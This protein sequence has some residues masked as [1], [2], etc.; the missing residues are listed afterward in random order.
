VY[1]VSAIPNSQDE[2]LQT[3]EGYGTDELTSREHMLAQSTSSSVTELTRDGHLGDFIGKEAAHQSQVN[4]SNGHTSMQ[5]ESY[6]S[7]GLTSREHTPAQSNSSP[8]TE[9]TRDGLL[10]ENGDFSSSS[11]QMGNNQIALEHTHC[12]NIETPPNQE[13]DSNDNWDLSSIMS[14][15]SST[16]GAELMISQPTNML[17]LGSQDDDSV[18]SGLA[19][20][21]MDQLLPSNLDGKG[22]IPFDEM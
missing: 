2:H 17:L 18:A 8:V 20:D 14:Y 22:S 1:G 21:P 11:T 7:D 5:L 4:A 3:A 16:S 6:G 13:E 9:L 10:R 19:I 12:A 15:F